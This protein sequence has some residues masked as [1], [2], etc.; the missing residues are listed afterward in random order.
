MYIETKNEN[1]RKFF[2]DPEK[3]NETFDLFFVCAGEYE[4]C[5]SFNR[6]LMNEYSKKGIKS[7]FYSTPGYHDWQVWRWCA[8]ELLTCL[9]R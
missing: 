7:V 3:F 6:E 2:S 5:C 1:A 9:F 4:H 8:R